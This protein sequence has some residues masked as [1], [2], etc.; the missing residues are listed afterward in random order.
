MTEIAKEP[1]VIGGLFSGIL[2]VEIISDEDSVKIQQ[3]E[4]RAKLME[5]WD[6]LPKRLLGG[7]PVNGKLSNF[8]Q[9]WNW[10]DPSVLIHGDSGIGKSVACMNLVQRLFRESIQAL[11]ARKASTVRWYSQYDL[12]RPY[13]RKEDQLFLK[14]PLETMVTRSVKSQLLFIED[15]NSPLDTNTGRLANIIKSRYN[16]GLPTIIMTGE[17]LEGFASMVGKTPLR[18]ITESV[19]SG[20]ATLI[21]V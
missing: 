20:A 21:E 4:L 16:S 18:W 19:N 17:T 6:M 8:Y 10:G 3:E 2:N 14:E 13:S 5:T 11:D 12:D 7:P 1:A 9:T 15:F